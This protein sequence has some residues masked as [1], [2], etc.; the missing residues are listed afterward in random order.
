MLI[1]VDD[2]RGLLV[3]RRSH[4][5]RQSRLPSEVGAIGQNIPSQNITQVVLGPPTYTL[6][7]VN[8]VNSA[9][10]TC[11]INAK[12]AAESITLFGQDSTWYGKPA[13]PNTCP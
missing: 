10:T 9:S 7:G 12:V 3:P 1:V 5:G 6:T 4:R 2:P 13:P 11:L 8:D